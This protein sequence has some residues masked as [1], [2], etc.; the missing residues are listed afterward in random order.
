M[1]LHSARPSPGYDDSTRPG[2]L[3]FA[4]HSSEFLG[5]T[6]RQPV[7][8]MSGQQLVENYAEGINV[9]SRA[10]GP[11][12]ICSGLAYAGVAIAA[13]VT[14]GSSSPPLT[15]FAMPKS[16]S[17]GVPLLVTSMFPGFRSR[18]IT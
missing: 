13:P 15:I 4:D 6:H 11:P 14:V 16:S 8:T 5:V 9:T 12:R 17:F 2:R 10:D 18:W 3:P 1:F 7:G